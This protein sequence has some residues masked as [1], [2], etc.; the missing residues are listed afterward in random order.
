MGD[1]KPDNLML[2]KTADCIWIDLRRE[3]LCIISIKYVQAQWIWQRRNSMKAGSMRQRISIFGKTLSEVLCQN[4]IFCCLYKAS[5]C[6]VLFFDVV[7]KSNAFSE[8]GDCTEE[9]KQ[10]SKETKSEQDKNILALCQKQYCI[11]HDHD[12]SLFA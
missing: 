7:R 10:N 2:V 8:Y 12:I 6:S 5:H 1:S 9:I 4:L 3:W 11:C